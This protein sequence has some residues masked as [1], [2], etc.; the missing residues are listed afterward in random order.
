M[1]ST[2]KGLAAKKAR[3][4]YHRHSLAENTMYHFNQFFGERTASRQFDKQVAVVQIRV[5]ALNTMDRPQYGRIGPDKELICPENR[6]KGEH[7]LLINLCTNAY[8]KVNL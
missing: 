3:I 1:G 6:V 8:M 4:R 2:S 5:V 7:S